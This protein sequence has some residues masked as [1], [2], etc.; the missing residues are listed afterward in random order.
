VSAKFTT[1]K[2][3]HPCDLLLRARLVPDRAGADTQV[4]AYTPLPR[5][6]QLPGAADLEDAWIGART[7]EDGCLSCREAYRLDDR[8][9][10]PQVLPG[11][12]LPPQVLP[13]RTAGLCEGYGLAGRVADGAGEVFGLDDCPCNGR[14]H[15]TLQI[16]ICLCSCTVQEY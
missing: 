14:L 11:M 5:L 7:G 10:P 2:W 4:I 9:L 13:E 16:Y 8:G 15:V 1:Q 6:R 12:R 3:S